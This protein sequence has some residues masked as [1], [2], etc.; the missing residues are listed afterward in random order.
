MKGMVTGLG[1]L[2]SNHDSVSLWFFFYFFYNV[3][4]ISTLAT[5]R[6]YN[7]QSFKLLYFT[8]LVLNDSFK[9]SS[10]HK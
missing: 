3:C 6:K 8:R 9:G 5:A 4:K 2:G 7:G 1:F 10:S